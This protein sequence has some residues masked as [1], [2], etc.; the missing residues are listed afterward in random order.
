LDSI[1][2]IRRSAAMDRVQSRPVEHQI[3]KAMHIVGFVSWFAGLFYM[4]R[5]LVY[6][7][8]ASEAPPDQRDVLLPQLELM[9]A[10]LWKIITV[11][12]MLV[13]LVAGAAML[14]LNWS[15]W[16]A[17]SW[18]HI[19][20]TLV[21]GLVG[22]HHVVGGVHRRLG[23]GGA[24]RWTS[25]RLRLLNEGATLLLFAIVFTAVFR[26]G[27]GLAWGAVGILVMGVVLAVAARLYERRRTS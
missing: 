15:L 4:V 22:Y 26:G 21:V 23:E 2:A 27:L 25:R 19:K 11:P 20:L 13:T 24:E 14:A 17:Q 3:A 6:R 9:S 18:L 1:L 8:E 16:M 5:L 7:A 12:A 10:R